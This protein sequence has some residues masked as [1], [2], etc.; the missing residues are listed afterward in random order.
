MKEFPIEKFDWG[1]FVVDGVEHS[2]NYGLRK[3][4]GKDLKIVGRNVESWKERR[5]H[6]VTKDMVNSVLKEKIDVL[7]IGTGFDGTLKVPKSVKNYLVENGVSEV[8]IK[9]TPDACNCY[10]K[11]YRQQRNVGLLVHGTC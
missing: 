6:I 11:L 5:G 3:G 10:N 7:V 2:K 8:I 9:K 1:K 4:Q